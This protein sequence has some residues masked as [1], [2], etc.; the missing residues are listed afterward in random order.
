MKILKGKL[1]FISLFEPIMLDEIDLRE[2]YF[3]LFEKL[4]GEKS[5]MDYSMNSIEISADENS[6]KVIKYENDKNDILI[7]LNNADGSFGMSNIGAYLPDILQRLN[8]MKVIASITDNSIKIT[9]D[10]KE[11]VFGIYYTR[12]NCCKIPNDKINTVCKIGQE[13]CCIFICA[14][15]DGFECLK[16]DSPSARMLLDRYSKKDMRASRIGNC[17]ILGRNEIVNM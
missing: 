13:D 14:G 1:K 2:Y 9:N 16:F 10:P 4:N 7:L 17:K 6:D 5:K 8:G 15:S 11:K 12:N 3:K